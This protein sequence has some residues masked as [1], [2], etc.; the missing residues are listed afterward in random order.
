MENTR[1]EIVLEYIN[2]I[3]D[4]FN[5]SF[6]DISPDMIT[7][8]VIEL[9]DKMLV[10]IA[11]CSKAFFKIEFELIYKFA[12]SN[13]VGSILSALISNGAVVSGTNGLIKSWLK[14]QLAH[15]IYKNCVIVARSK[16]RSELAMKLM[17]I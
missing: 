16:Y 15:P 8:D 4:L 3:N 14:K 13:M 5:N 9:V 6:G 17:G 2:V 7:D 1:D 11:E 12:I 10:S